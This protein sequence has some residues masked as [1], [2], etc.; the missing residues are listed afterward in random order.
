MVGCSVGAAVGDAVRTDTSMAVVALVKLKS[1][2]TKVG[3]VGLTGITV[4][5]SVGAPVGT[6]GAR[7]ATRERTAPQAV[8]VAVLLQP[9]TMQVTNS[10]SNSFETLS[11][12]QSQLNIKR[13][14][15]API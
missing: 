9:D 6:P 1:A 2:L 3:F 10:S 11:R 8:L 15:Q 7:E 4:G 12:L 14:V 13:I 5:A